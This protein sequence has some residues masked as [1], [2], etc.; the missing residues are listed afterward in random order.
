MNY[1]RWLQSTWY[2]LKLFFLDGVLTILPITLTIA[3]FLWFF[4]LIKTWL[5][6]IYYIEPTFFKQI[7]HS[8]I[9]FVL[10]LILLVGAIFRTY[11]IRTFLH[12]LEA[13]IN[14]IPLINPVYSGIKQLVQAFATPEKLTFKKVVLTEFPRPGIYSIGFLT[15]EVPASITPDP[16][17]KYHMIFIPTTPNP[18]TGFLI[19]VPENEIKVIDISRQEA[20][21]FII[22]GGIIQ[23]ERF[24]KT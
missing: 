19:I 6:P 1:P 3:L 22:S 5:A 17:I 15:N 20:M 24:A 13:I 23:P 18:T 8:E 14:K 7:P 9:F 4:K 11:L 2:Y 12:L 21:S 10:I 16:L